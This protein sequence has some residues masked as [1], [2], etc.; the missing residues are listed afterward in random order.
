MSIKDDIEK[1]EQKIEAAQRQEAIS[2]A[3]R[4]NAQR[5]YDQALEAIKIDFSVKSVEEAEALLASQEEELESLVRS[6]E[7]ALGETQ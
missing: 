3:A 1:L 5:L 2:V 6:A 7:I 4:D